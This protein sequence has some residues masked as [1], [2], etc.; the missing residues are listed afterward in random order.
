MFKK[1]LLT[2]ASLFL[3][4]QAMAYITAT[5][6]N[7]GTDAYTRTHILIVGKGN[8]LSTLLQTTAA[9]KAKKYA[10]LFPNEQVYL[11]SVNETG[12]DDNLELLSKY[13]FRNVTEKRSW[14]FDSSDVFKEMSQFKKIAS[15]D[16][17]SHSVAYYGVILDGKLNR[18]DPKK[19]GYEKLAPNFTPD[20]YA[21]LHGCNSGQFLAPILSHQWNIPVAGSFTSTDFQRLHENG[22]WYF[23]DGRKPSE[24]S[25]VSTNKKSYQ[26]NELCVEGACRRLTPDNHPYNGYWGDFEGG[27]LGFFKFFCL[28]NSME[29]CQKGMARAAIAHVSNLPITK[30]S[31]FE[32]YEKVVFDILCPISAK[33]DLRGECIAGLRNAAATG[34]TYDS[35]GGKSLQCDFKGCKAKFKCERI[36]IIDLLK[37]KSCTVINLRESSKT[38][39]QVE[40]YKAYIRG[41]KLLQAQ[42]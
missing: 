36:P 27:G 14:N 21:V 22:S 8:E 34:G 23:D 31:S 19:D 6:G 2:M 33:K 3:S 39:T 15:V 7:N 5:Y 24:G 30:N 28:K 9:A 38:T 26:R 41:W 35:F 10:E 25:F 1:I 40:E 17:F 13:G 12:K 16:I 32:D 42:K 29:D 4:T 11:I 20:A 37:E 18:M